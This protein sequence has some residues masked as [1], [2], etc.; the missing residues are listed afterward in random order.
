MRAI[1]SPFFV[2]VVQ[3]VFFGLVFGLIAKVL[4]LLKTLTFGTLNLEGFASATPPTAG[5]V[6]TP[7]RRS[8][9]P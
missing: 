4:W 1:R 9:L 7:S 3:V 8:C 6:R 2:T 5:A